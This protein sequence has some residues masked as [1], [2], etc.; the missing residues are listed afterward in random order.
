MF[1]VNVSYASAYF[2][3]TAVRHCPRGQFQCE[4]LNCTFSF[5]VC[6]LNDDCG[7]GSDERDCELRQCEPWQFKCANHKCVPR[8]WM[9][10]GED[11]CGD[12]SD[13]P[14]TCG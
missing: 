6:D 8:G 3:F 5:N 10:D 11:D 1:K 7:D 13:E 12:N 2:L 14:A 4:N 9:C